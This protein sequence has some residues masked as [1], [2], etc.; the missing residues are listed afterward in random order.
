MKKKKRDLVWELEG[1][2]KFKK[3]LIFLNLVFQK[4]I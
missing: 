3:K 1:K 4:Q 2:K